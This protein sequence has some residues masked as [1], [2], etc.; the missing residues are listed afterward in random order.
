MS[1]GARDPE[2]LETLFEDA[3]LLGDHD[4]LRDIFEAGAIVVTAAGAELRG[5]DE[6]VL[7]PHEPLVAGCARVLQAGRTALL[8]GPRTVSVVRRGADRAWRYAIS[9]RDL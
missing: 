4:A 5:R 2:E 7:G 6:I 3:L 9:L 8:L 1:G